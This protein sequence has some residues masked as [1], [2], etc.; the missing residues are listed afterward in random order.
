M[1]DKSH[2][3]HYFKFCENNEQN[4]LGIIY[5]FMFKLKNWKATFLSTENQNI[6]WTNAQSRTAFCHIHQINLQIALNVTKLYYIDI[7]CCIIKRSL[8]KPNKTK[9]NLE[10]LHFPSPLIKKVDLSFVS[11][12][13]RGLR[14]LHKD[15]KQNH[16]SEL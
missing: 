2:E 16:I 10:G 7:F 3:K 12:I 13:A 1:K 14:V 5:F 15:T 11:C 6:F 8:L 9:S 4:C